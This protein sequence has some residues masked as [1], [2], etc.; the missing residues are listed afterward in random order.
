[1]KLNHIN[2]LG[3]LGIIGLLPYLFELP[4][5]FKL[6]KLFFFLF[7]IEGLFKSNAI[8]K[9]FKHLK[10]FKFLRIIHKIVPLRLSDI[11]YSLI[12]KNRE[13]IISNCEIPKSHIKTKFIIN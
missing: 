11:I 10:K 3:F 12:S 2:L 1:M 6:F 7:W 4:N 13:K 8:M 9:I 5:Y